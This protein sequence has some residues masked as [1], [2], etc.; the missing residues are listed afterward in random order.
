MFLRIKNMQERIDGAKRK[1]TTGDK[2]HKE[3]QCDGKKGFDTFA[4][5]ERAVSFCK[6][7]KD[8]R[9]YKCAFCHKWHVGHSY[10]KNNKPPSK[11]AVARAEELLEGEA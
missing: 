4:A 9:I 7:A 10:V 11:R 6:S 1:S 3:S 8:S 2:V 5:A